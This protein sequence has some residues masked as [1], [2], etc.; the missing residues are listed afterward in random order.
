MQE[1]KVGR[2]GVIIAVAAAILAGL[3][4][5][6]SAIASGVILAG[7]AIA[8]YLLSRVNVMKTISQEGSSVQK[9]FLIDQFNYYIGV[10]NAEVQDKR[11]YIKNELSTLTFLNLEQLK[12]QIDAAAL[13]YD[14]L[15]ALDLLE[16]EEVDQDAAAEALPSVS[17]SAQGIIHFLDQEQ[18]KGLPQWAKDVV[19]NLRAAADI[20]L[21]GE[22]SLSGHYFHPTSGL[23][24][25]MRGHI[26]P[27]F[28]RNA[29]VGYRLVSQGKAEFDEGFRKA[30]PKP[31]ELVAGWDELRKHQPRVIVQSRWA[32]LV[33][34]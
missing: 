20:Y 2:L 13:E 16:D 11:E 23:L 12:N 5:T 18:G 1:I 19:Q 32:W 3:V 26:G 10:L 6:S 29:Y 14:R 30:I 7:A 17:Q 4:V 33:G 21:N 31:Y 8:V 25:N 34:S 15:E 9:G 24:A 22:T 28:N 27:V